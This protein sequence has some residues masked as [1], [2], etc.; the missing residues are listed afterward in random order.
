MSLCIWRMVAGRVWKQECHRPG[1]RPSRRLTSHRPNVR[2]QK[3]EAEGRTPG[4]R[5]A[6]YTDDSATIA[7][8]CSI[9]GI[10]RPSVLLPHGPGTERG[11]SRTDL[12]SFTC[13]SLRPQCSHR[14]VADPE[15][16]VCH[17]LEGTELNGRCAGTIRAGLEHPERR[18]FDPVY[19]SDMHANGH[20]S[21]T[22]N[23][24]PRLGPCGGLT[25]ASRPFLHL[26]L[27]I[28]QNALAAR[29]CLGDPAA[30]IDA[31]M[32]LRDIGGSRPYD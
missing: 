32:P 2:S 25:E 16:E 14:L 6:A 28:L 24:A 8:E 21:A 12:P 18:D 31:N 20:I 11:P 13:S 1:C 26:P 17:T 3:N 27:P 22:A 15:T 7:A 29:Y 5:I 4:L 30:P 9:G 23:P 19:F 10:E